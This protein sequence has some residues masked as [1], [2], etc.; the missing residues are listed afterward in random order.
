MGDGSI[1]GRQTS[2]RKDYSEQNANLFHISR[3]LRRGRI[4]IKSLTVL[5][6]MVSAGGES[7]YVLSKVIFKRVSRVE[8]THVQKHKLVFCQQILVSEA[9]NSIA[10][11]FHCLCEK[12]RCRGKVLMQLLCMRPRFIRVDRV[13]PAAPQRPSVHTN[14]LFSMM[15]KTQGLLIHVRR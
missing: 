11:F 5:A 9:L 13:S 12:A 6:R 7:Y 2:C 10:F 15:E 14:I 1:W 4:C 3:R 8:R